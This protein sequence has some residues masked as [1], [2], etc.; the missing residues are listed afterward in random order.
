MPEACRDIDTNERDQARIIFIANVAVQSRSKDV[1]K[2]AKHVEK[3]I[4]V[5]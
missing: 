2:G 3:Q 4:E 5:D 1:M